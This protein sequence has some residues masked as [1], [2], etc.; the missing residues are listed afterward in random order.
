[1]QGRRKENVDDVLLLSDSLACSVEPVGADDA[2]G[3]EVVGR[4]ETARG[5]VALWEGNVLV[6]LLSWASFWAVGR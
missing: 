6:S 1:M 4:A 2:H 5:E 3:E